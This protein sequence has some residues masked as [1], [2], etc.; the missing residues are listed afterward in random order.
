MFTFDYLN[1]FVISIFDFGGIWV[2]IIP[3]PGH[4]IL[5]TFVF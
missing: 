1:F 3:V 5:D 2:L 4:C